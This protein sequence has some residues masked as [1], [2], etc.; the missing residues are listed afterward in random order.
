MNKLCTKCG[1]YAVREFV[2]GD[3]IAKRCYWCL[4]EETVVMFKKE[5]KRHEN[6]RR[7]S[8]VS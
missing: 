3:T 1:H 6:K 5:D 7:T 8:K 2:V 4:N